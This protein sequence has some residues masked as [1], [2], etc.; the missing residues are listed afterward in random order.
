MFSDL[1]K[2]EKVFQLFIT[3]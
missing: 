2:K 1:Y 3:S